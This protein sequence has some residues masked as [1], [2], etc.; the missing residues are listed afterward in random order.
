[1]LQ[2]YK[3]VIRHGTNIPKRRCLLFCTLFITFIIDF[4]KK[5]IVAR[6]LVCLVLGPTS[7]FEQYMILCV[8]IQ[9]NTITQHWHFI[10]YSFSYILDK[11]TCFMWKR[12]SR[13]LI[14]RDTMVC[15]ASTSKV[16]KN[17]NIVHTLV[18]LLRCF[19]FLMSCFRLIQP[20][21]KYNTLNEH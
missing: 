15:R 21:N 18:K 7:G 10:F 1:M 8:V 19:S 14:S 12:E 6:L 9:L 16:W 13:T 11:R 5:Y 20:F 2:V 17:C 3:R 4:K